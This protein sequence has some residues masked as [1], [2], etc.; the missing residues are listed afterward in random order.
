[1]PI[2][3]YKCRKC[4]H[5]E[6][7]LRKLAMRNRKLICKKCGSPMDR[8]LASAYFSLKGDGF[9]KPSPTREE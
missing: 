8:Q 1:M 2:Y 6:D 5:K 7:K 3:T 9:Y 4:K